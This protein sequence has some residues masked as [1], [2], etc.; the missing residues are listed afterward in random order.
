M[1]ELV[2]AIQNI[3][4]IQSE[5]IDY[6]LLEGF[7]GDGNVQT[8]EALAG[9]SIFGSNSYSVFEFCRIASQGKDD[10]RI[11]SCF[12]AKFLTEF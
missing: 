7:F 3:E 12:L 6:D 2:L 11:Q 4:G 5:S 9:E 10:V 1:K 8:G